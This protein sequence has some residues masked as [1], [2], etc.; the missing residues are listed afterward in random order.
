MKSRKEIKSYFTFFKVVVL[1]KKWIINETLNLNPSEV[2]AAPYHSTRKRL[3]SG[4]TSWSVF[5][6]VNPPV[7]RRYIHSHAPLNRGGGY[8]LRMC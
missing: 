7:Q 1:D 8:I 4:K 5:S 2:A 6:K 3:D